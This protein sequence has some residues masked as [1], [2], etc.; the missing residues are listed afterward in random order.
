[1]NLT[2]ELTDIEYA[3]IQ[4]ALTKAA[5]ARTLT[6]VGR[7]ELLHLQTLLAE[8]SVKEDNDG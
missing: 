3:A 5:N 1:M 7:L 8:A 4:F 6:D 2:I